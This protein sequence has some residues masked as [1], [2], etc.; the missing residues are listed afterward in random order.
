MKYCYDA[1]LLLISLCCLV[2]PAVVLASERSV[3][4][5]DQVW[6]PDWAPSWEPSHQIPR[7]SN[8]IHITQ[9]RPVYARY[10]CLNRG[11]CF[12][13]ETGE[14]GCECAHG[15]MGQRCEYKSLEGSYTLFGDNNAT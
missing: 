2:R 1:L 9:C 14:Y 10:F 15:F 6:K 8:T 11:T 5:Q 13:V 4:R 12:F 3:V 7:P